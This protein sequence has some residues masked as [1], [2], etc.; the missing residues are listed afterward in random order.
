MYV[1]LCICLCIWSTDKINRDH[2]SP[3]LSNQPLLDTSRLSSILSQL[4]DLIKRIKCVH[5]L[6]SPLLVLLAG[7]N[8]N[9]QSPIFK[10]WGQI[11]VMQRVCMQYCCQSWIRD[12]RD[13]WFMFP[14]SWR[15]S[16]RAVQC[17]FKWHRP[18]P[19]Q[20]RTSSTPPWSPLNYVVKGAIYIW[21]L[22]RI[23]K[24]GGLIWIVGRL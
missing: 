17:A 4:G 13:W 10:G 1:C 16:W 3:L 20:V 6:G 5:G 19:S 14:K 12:R 9:F 18:P 2:H 11:M 22:F 23:Q 21:M 7:H 24:S 8:P 15:E